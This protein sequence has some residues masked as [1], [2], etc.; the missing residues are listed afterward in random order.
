MSMIQV[1]Y[2][3]YS[4]GTQYFFDPATNVTTY[5]FPNN[6]IVLDP[7]TLTPI[8]VDPAE[9]P[10]YHMM[11]QAY[12]SLLLEQQNKLNLGTSNPDPPPSENSN[13]QPKIE[14]PP[15]GDSNITPEPEKIDQANPSN[16]EKPK[17]P[18]PIEPPKEESAPVPTEPTPSE[19]KT[20]P[21][22][23]SKDPKL[24]SK[25]QSKQPQEAPNAN[26][27]KDHGTDES[28]VASVESTNQPLRVTRSAAIF[29]TVQKMPKESPLPLLRTDSTQKSSNLSSRKSA[30][31]T[32]SPLE[33]DTGS[34]SH[35]RRGRRRDRRHNSTALLD[36][37]DAVSKF[38][39][40]KSANQQQEQRKNS[41]VPD[42]NAPFL[43]TDIRDD[44]QKFQ[45]EDYA[46]QFFRE[47]RK[48][49]VFSRKLVSAE[50][51]TQFS[52]EPLTSSLIKLS[53]PADQKNAVKCFKL[54]LTYIGVT[55]G[56][57]NSAEQLVQILNNNPSLY[58]EVYFQL[59]KQT[60]QN[61][62][63]EWELKTW[64]LFLIIATIFPSSRNGEIWIKS[65]LAQRSS[66]HRREISHLAQLCY[67]RFTSR[68]A[69]GK[70]KT[71]LGLGYVSRIPQQINNEYCAFDASIYEHL[72]FQRKKYPN[73]PIPIIVYQMS[74]AILQK[75]P[76][77]MEGIFRLPGNIKL[78][79]QMASDYS[80][81]TIDFQ[82]AKLFDVLSLFKMWFRDIPN[83]IVP[84][85]TLPCLKT[86]FETNDYINFVVKNLP[87]AHLKLFG[88]LV[89]FLQKLIKFENVTKMGSKNMAIVFAP[90]I[91][92]TAADFTEPG[93]IKQYS[94]ISIAFMTFMLDN[95]DTKEYYPLT[96]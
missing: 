4:D 10:E 21:I 76:G 82:N 17:E 87:T 8:E 57:A 94:D 81:G 1:Y 5:Q 16:D 75:N 9:N 89:G 74:E 36:V 20:T 28:S 33:T 58:D 83:P 30:I 79:Q 84:A 66:A 6:G 35:K 15:A 7:T 67:I 65:H 77:A 71:D 92:Q 90:N 55:K 37:P 48:R 43:P 88:F 96:V 70:P 60:R 53:N 27:E 54:I 93:Q 78:V 56:P 39:E 52:K 64:N 24:N 45:V 63:P 73:F 62:E 26:V 69:I 95:W 85:E 22:E 2:R 13:T 80:K 12:K 50:Q 61:P 31:Y 86:A 49:R 14:A 18:S 34:Q 72:W 40:K 59:I 3:Y 25:E 19:T 46:K 51:M 47:H 32:T 44:I 23:E 29:E 91:V 41:F 38:D 68:C 11:L 42:K